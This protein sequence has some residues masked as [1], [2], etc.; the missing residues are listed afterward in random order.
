[1][2]CLQ[3]MEHIPANEACGASPTVKWSACRLHMVSANGGKPH[4]GRFEP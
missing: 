3:N 2:G 4:T 1:M